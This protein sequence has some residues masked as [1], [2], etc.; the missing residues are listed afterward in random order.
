MR[1]WFIS[2]AIFS[3]LV[4]TDNKLEQ[5]RIN[6]LLDGHEPA[7]FHQGLV[8]ANRFKIRQDLPCQQYIGK[9]NKRSFVS[10]NI[11]V[12][13]INSKGARMINKEKKQEDTFLLWPKKEDLPDLSLSEDIL[14]E[15]V[16][17]GNSLSVQGELPR[18]NPNPNPRPS[19]FELVPMKDMVPIYP[20]QPPPKIVDTKLSLPRLRR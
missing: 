2:L 4:Y 16:G 10:T 7:G 13:Y 5:Y 12:Y 19:L 18:P 20:P 3:M 1:W 14:E 15:T 17:A 8:P 6:L 9:A 11:E